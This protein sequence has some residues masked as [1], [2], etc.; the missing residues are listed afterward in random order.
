[1]HSIETEDVWVDNSD[2]DNENTP[3]EFNSF[4]IP[5]H[6]DLGNNTINGRTC[7]VNQP[8]LTTGFNMNPKCWG[9]IQTTER[10]GTSGTFVTETDIKVKVSRPETPVSRNQSEEITKDIPSTVAPSTDETEEVTTTIKSKETENSTPIPKH[11][12]YDLTHPPTLKN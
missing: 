1:M 11:L 9:N 3:A 2:S 4:P 7:P 10:V 5:S 8:L 12:K 6:W